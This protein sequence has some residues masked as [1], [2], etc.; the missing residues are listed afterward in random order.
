MKCF[1]F[2]IAMFCFQCEGSKRE[3][4]RH[5][6]SSRS[7]PAEKKMP[8]PPP[9]SPAYIRAHPPPPLCMADGKLSVYVGKDNRRT[10]TTMGD[11]NADEAA[12]NRIRCSGAVPSEKCLPF[13]L[14][15]EKSDVDS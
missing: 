13:E 8:E 7:A 11:Y 1:F 4:H 12:R 14:R 5:E 10:F 3:V 15:S 2:V 6:L 9:G